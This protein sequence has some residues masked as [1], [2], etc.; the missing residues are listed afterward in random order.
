MSCIRIR[1]LPTYDQ[2]SQNTANQF[3]DYLPGRLPF[4]SPHR[5]RLAVQ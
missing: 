1:V 4:R 5:G 2:L 3:A